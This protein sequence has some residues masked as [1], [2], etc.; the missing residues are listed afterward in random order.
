MSSKIIHDVVYVRLSFLLKAWC[1]TI[2]INLI[3]FNH[4][5]VP[6][7]VGCF[8]LLTV[9]NN[10]PV[11]KGVKMILWDSAFSSFALNSFQ[12]PEVELL[13]RWLILFLIFHY[14][15]IALWHLQSPRKLFSIT[16]HCVT[17]PS[18]FLKTR[19]FPFTLSLCCTP[20]GGSICG[21]CRAPRCILSLGTGWPPDPVLKRLVGG[22]RLTVHFTPYAGPFRTWEDDFY[23]RNGSWPFR[24]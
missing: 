21:A 6:G 11:D 24:N 19:L 9:V 22:R 7:H 15:V 20:T 23:L 1:S 5:S 3:S 16:V 12:H 2:C 18:C 14:G 13:H 4:S 10:V 17:N 8:Q